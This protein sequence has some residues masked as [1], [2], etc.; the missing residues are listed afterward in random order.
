MEKAT[1]AL[2]TNNG[3]IGGGEVMLLN[4]A[5]ALTELGF[6]VRVVGPKE[7][8]QLVDSARSQGLQ[9]VVLDAATRRE[10]LTAL[11]R[12]DATQRA[13]LLWCNGLVPAVATSGHPN[14]IVHLHQRPHGL[15]RP[16]SVLAR[17]RAVMTLVP[18]Q[19]MADAI[20]G[21]KV[22][23]NW[24]DGVRLGQSAPKS[25]IR[26]PTRLGFLGRPS[27]DKGVDVL[28]KALQILNV[29]NP[30][31]FRLILAG[32]P[33]FVGHEAQGQVTAALRPVQNL[34]ESTGWIRPEEFFEQVDILVCPSTW[35]E[36]FGLVVAE[37]MS[38]RVPFVISDAGALPEVAGPDH[39]WIFSAGDA[40]DLAT[41]LE[42]A[43][44]AEEGSAIEYAFSRWKQQFSPPAG[45]QRVSELLNELRVQQTGLATTAGPLEDHP[46]L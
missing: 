11:R 30:G 21:S 7:P 27:I 44:N 29:N 43:V 24:V 19:N 17:L 45:K 1:I 36:P 18:S 8:S 38:A 32:E 2:A 34:V 15:Q 13:G 10:Y 37:A 20:P 26:R 42:R 16:I 39:P 14:R 12:W 41:V 40:R 5:H 35:P 9:T 25:G 23:H 3:D 46:G 6:E 31:S 4:I 28:A 33:R 22:L